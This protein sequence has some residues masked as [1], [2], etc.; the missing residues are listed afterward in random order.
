[1]FDLFWRSTLR[2]EAAVIKALKPRGGI[3]L[4][5]GCAT[6]TFFENFPIPEWQLFG[7]D[8]SRFGIEAARAAY[9]AELFLGTLRE[10]HYPDS[11]FDV[12]SLLDAF[13]YFADPI[14]ELLEVRRVLKPDGLLALEIEGLN[15]TL[16]RK[17]GPV[18][19]LLDRRW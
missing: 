13:C 19:L 16:V 15:Y 10:A 7:N 9:N 1:M 2:R 14:S 8:P 4:D 5:I 3:L 6:G 17:H 12:I 11:F 18:S